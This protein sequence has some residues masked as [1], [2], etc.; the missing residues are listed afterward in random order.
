MSVLKITVEVAGYTED[1]FWFNYPQEEITVTDNDVI[2]Q[3][4]KM[5]M[6]SE[7]N[8]ETSGV[9]YDPVL[10]KYLN[11]NVFYLS[12]ENITQLIEL[13]NKKCNL[14]I[15]IYTFSMKIHIENDTFIV[16]DSYD[17][18]FESDKKHIALCESAQN[19]YGYDGI[20][21]NKYFVA[22]LYKM[23]EYYYREHGELDI[24]NEHF[25]YPLI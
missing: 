11:M 23:Y 10:S 18:D 16:V 13:I 6:E 20:F 25:N 7:L 2:C 21:Y 22:V 24:V 19:A 17:S 3:L 14:D 9:R 5:Y 1:N 12:T 15:D 4:K 8:L